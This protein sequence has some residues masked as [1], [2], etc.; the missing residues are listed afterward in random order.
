MKKR[1]IP[2]DMSCAQPVQREVL[3]AVVDA[4]FDDRAQFAIR[5][6]LDE[7]ISNAVHHGNRNDPSKEVTV[8]YDVTPERATISVE[9]QGH[10][11]APNNVPD[12][13]LEENCIKPHGRGVMLIRAYM[14]DVQFSERG[15]RVTMVK[16][17]DC[18]LPRVER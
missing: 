7:A 9:D 1:V 18:D 2:S 13:T 8:E 10:G 3:Q 11:F 12:P 6:A 17:R 4:G 15:N 5:L 14:T 16:S